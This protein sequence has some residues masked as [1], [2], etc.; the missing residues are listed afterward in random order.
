M[1]APAELLGRVAR[2]EEDLTLARSALRRKKP[3]LYGATFHTQQCVEKYLKALQVAVD[4]PCGK[5]LTTTHRCRSVH[6]VAGFGW[7]KIPCT[8][9]QGQATG[10]SAYLQRSYS[11]TSNAVAAWRPL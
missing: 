10:C 6:I 9:R 8:S 2:A 5:C 11:P 4:S 3:L 1:S 7:T